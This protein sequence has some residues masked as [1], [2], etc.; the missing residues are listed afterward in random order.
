MPEFF[1]RFFMKNVLTPK[2][3]ASRWKKLI[4]HSAGLVMLMAKDNDPEH[5]IELGRQFQ[6]FGLTLTKYNIKHA[7]VN[8]PCEETDVRQKLMHD[9]KLNGY[10]PLLLL[11]IG[12]GEPLPYSFRRKLSEIIDINKNI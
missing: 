4:K 11:R 3:E 10:S 1:G 2:S 9:M 5:W 12:Y 8:M 6:R 7:H